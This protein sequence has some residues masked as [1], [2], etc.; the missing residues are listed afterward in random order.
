MKSFRRVIKATDVQWG[1]AVALKAPPL[2][3]P[4]PPEVVKAHA[5][6]EEPAESVGPELEK[7]VFPAF[8]V[9]QMESDQDAPAATP[10]LAEP[11]PDL[12]AL[13]QNALAE[14]EVEKARLVQAAQERAT[15]IERAA[16]A[17]SAEIE[18]LARAQS[19]EFEQL[20]DEQAQDVVRAAKEQA[21]EVTRQARR[22]GYEA[23]EMDAGQLLLAAQGVLDEVRAWRTAMFAQSEQAI[24]DLVAHIAK[25]IF[26]E[27]VALPREALETAFGRALTEARTRGEALR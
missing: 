11:L 6:W 24:L 23:A 10:G 27:G 15:E 2:P 8:E 20:A 7:L 4:P 13:M 22:E 16:Q 17:K 19:A 21:A 14:A 5:A 9:L 25:V 18:R 1:A 12:T 3:P 26:G